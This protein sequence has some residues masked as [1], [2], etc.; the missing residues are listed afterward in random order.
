MGFE[1]P[2]AILLGGVGECCRSIALCLRRCQLESLLNKI[3]GPGGRA[4][5]MNFRL[6]SRAHLGNLRGG[7]QLLESPREFAHIERTERNAKAGAQ[8]LDQI[9]VVKMIVGERRD[10]M[11]LADAEDA[12]DGADSAMR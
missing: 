9:A 3:R 6:H 4:P 1:W 10:Q 8:F 2:P 7:G 12:G 5:M 11:G